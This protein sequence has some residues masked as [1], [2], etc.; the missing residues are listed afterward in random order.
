M[1][2]SKYVVVNMADN[3]SSKFAIITES[4][5]EMT[6]PGSATNY[7]EILNTYQGLLRFTINIAS[8]GN[9]QMAG[10]AFDQVLMNGGQYYQ[11]TTN[12]DPLKYLDPCLYENNLS[13]LRLSSVYGIVSYSKTTPVPLRQT[14]LTLSNGD[15]YGPTTTDGVFYFTGMADGAYTITG[16]CALPWGSD[17]LTFDATLILRYAAAVPGYDLSNLKKRAADVNMTNTTGSPD[18]FD[19]TLLLRRAASVPTPT[20]TAPNYVFDGPFPTPPSGYSVNVSAGLGTV[21]L[22]GLCSGDVNGSYTP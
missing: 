7:K 14:T 11:S 2:I 13:T 12:T 15:T 17:Q 19:A 3:T 16:T 21:S 6:Q 20:W 1:D 10:I 5:F 9:T 18:T 4:L 8:G 22:K